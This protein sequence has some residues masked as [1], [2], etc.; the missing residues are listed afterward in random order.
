MK[1]TKSY[2]AAYREDWR[3]WLEKNHERETEIWLIYYK[4]HTGKPRVAYHDAVEE[5]LC[6]G[7]IDSTIQRM[8][9]ERYAQKFTP[10]RSDSNWSALNKRRVVNLIQEGRMMQAGLKTLTYT[11]SRDD[12]GRST[13]HTAEELK[14][15][16][17]LKKI[18]SS[19]RK[20]WDTFNQLAPS[21][22]R[23]YIRWITAA[24][25]EETRNKRID[26][27]MKLLAQKRKLG[28]K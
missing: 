23:N 7:W 16:L 19:N 27:A 21:Y 14:P 20:A 28:M 12:Y 6:F 15:P 24:K 13:V 25:T 9:D 18:L 2:Y 8:D 5:A 11:D 4:K 1:I 26:E 10:R 3:A 17:Y 22:R